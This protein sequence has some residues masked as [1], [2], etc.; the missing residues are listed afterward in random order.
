MLLVAACGEPVSPSGSGEPFAFVET[1]P[2]PRRVEL[3]RA[4]FARRKFKAR[5]GQR[6]GDHDLEGYL[7]KVN[8]LTRVFA[9]FG[10]P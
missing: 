5:P 1:I 8:A 3:S 7:A 2:T 9:R 4:E 6:C 10:R